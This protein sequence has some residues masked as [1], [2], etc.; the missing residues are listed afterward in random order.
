MDW[1]KSGQLEKL[2]FVGKTQGNGI[3]LFVQPLLSVGSQLA[4]FYQL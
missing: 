4:K 3:N 1:E 2:K